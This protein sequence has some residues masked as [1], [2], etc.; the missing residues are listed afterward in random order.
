[1]PPWRKA[2]VRRERADLTPRR[3]SPFGV[4]F[5]H[6]DLGAILF[7]AQPPDPLVEGRTVGEWEEPPQPGVANML[8]GLTRI[9]RACAHMRLKS[10][11]ACQGMTTFNAGPIVSVGLQEV[12]NAEQ[13]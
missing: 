3:K 1:M 11:K 8:A 4:P 9:R 2:C 12:P 5:G 7:E 6:G 10:V 13:P